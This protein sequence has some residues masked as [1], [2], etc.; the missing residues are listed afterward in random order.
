[1][2]DIN[3]T[4]L[5]V[6]ISFLGFVV[7]MKALF[8]DPLMQTID[9]RE[10]LI[11]GAAASAKQALESQQQVSEMISQKLHQAYAQAQGVV[12]QKTDVAQQ[13]ASELKLSATQSANAQL[14]KAVVQLNDQAQQSYQS[15]QG[16][17]KELAE[18]IIQKLN[19]T[20]LAKV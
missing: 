1:M 5:I 11:D 16:E 7:L 13:K 15:L 18:K 17:Q 3:G 20:Q 6:F 10:T 4:F 19:N 2:F 12:Q 8:F 14:D 9:Q